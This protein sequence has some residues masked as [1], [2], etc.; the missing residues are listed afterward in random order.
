MHFWKNYS[1]TKVKLWNLLTNISYNHLKSIDFD[2]VSFIIDYFTYILF[3]FKLFFLEWKFDVERDR[4]YVKMLWNYLILYKF[5]IYICRNDDF[6]VWNKLS[7]KYQNT[8]DII[9][10][11]I[12]EENNNF[13]LFKEFFKKNA[14]LFQYIYSD[15]FLKYFC[16]RDDYGV[17]SKMAFKAAYAGNQNQQESFTFCAVACCQTRKN[18][19]RWNCGSCRMSTATMFTVKTSSIKTKKR[20]IKNA[21]IVAEKILLKKRSKGKKAKLLNELETSNL[22]M[23]RKNSNI[24]KK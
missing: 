5:Y 12:L 4:E 20:K 10:N 3:N 14:L 19:N 16:R 6:I 23:R 18:W 7:L 1:P 21:D 24:N 2:S 9:N 11:F 15:I 17:K 22:H 13:M 8:F